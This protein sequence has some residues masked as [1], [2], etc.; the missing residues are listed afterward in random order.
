MSNNSFSISVSQGR[1]AQIHDNREYT[2]MNSDWS[3]KN[4]NI[5]IKKSE[6]YQSVFNDLFRDSLAEYN[7]K[8]KREDRKKSY[9]YYSE[10]EHGKGPEKA[11]YEYVFQIGNRENLGL[12]DNDFDD[13]KWYELKRK[14][15]FKEASDYVKKHLNKDPRREELKKL[16]TNEMKKLE[17]KYTKFHFW[18]ITGHDDEPC[19][20]MH[21]HVAFTPVADGY[22]NGMSTRDSL[23]K[24]LRQMGFETDQYMLG[25]QK[26]Q[27]DVK[28]NIEKAMAEAGYER[29]HLNNT[30]AH[31][32]V[33][34]FKLKSQNEKL[35]AKKE[36]LT[37]EI[38]VAERHLQSLKASE[39]DYLMRCRKLQVKEKENALK[40]SE[41]N[42]KIHQTN[43]ILNELHNMQN[44]IQQNPP[45]SLAEFAKKYTRKQP[46]K[47]IS[48]I[49]GKQVGWK[50]DDKGKILTEWHNC[51]DDWK[52]HEDSY[53][54]F[55]SK[56]NY[57]S[58]N[59]NETTKEMY[60]EYDI[61][62]S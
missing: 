7:A 25:I 17:D 26:W 53:A 42:N 44:A 24:S 11:I 62:F 8:Q 33:N 50:K 21:F 43:D 23:T 20:T 39:N 28:D 32:S 14:G 12:T 41:L 1:V 54:K 35:I 5:T 60:G 58:D 45:I 46:I 19:G 2:P 40:S 49:T 52:N 59:L 18:T 57:I 16:L 37:S 9:D 34:Q 3:L 13:E 61:C 10:I 51:F 29:E 6:D 31:L 56:V 36:S 30:E 4:R 22:K 27:N 55:M 48:P 38:K 15:R 47:Q